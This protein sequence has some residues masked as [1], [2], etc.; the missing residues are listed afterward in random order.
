M[1]GRALIPLRRGRR[2]RRRAE[3]RPIQVAQNEL[4]QRTVLPGGTL[5]PEDLLR[6]VERHTRC[7]GIEPRD[8]DLRRSEVLLG[9]PAVP[10]MASH[11]CAPWRNRARASARHRIAPRASPWSAAR[12]NHCSAVGVILGDAVALGVAQLQDRSAR[13]LALLGRVARGLLGC[14]RG[15]RG[16]RRGSGRLDRGGIAART[17]L[18]CRR[19]ERS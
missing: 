1:R 8:G 2:V 12:W 19:V 11:S 15:R 13:R 14:G 4:R 7:L 18:R 16:W 6:M 9:R 10:S 17:G 5:K 3:R